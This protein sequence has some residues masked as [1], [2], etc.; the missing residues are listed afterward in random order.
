MLIIRLMK[1]SQQVLEMT[2]A[3]FEALKVLPPAESHAKFTVTVSVT[4]YEVD[5]S[6]AKVS[7]VNSANSTATV[8]VNVKAVTDG[9]DLKI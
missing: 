3:E 1:P 4:S 7:N 8:K 2:S 5:D 9:I 6:G